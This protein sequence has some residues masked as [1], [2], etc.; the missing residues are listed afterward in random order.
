MSHSTLFQHYFRHITW[1]AYMSYYFYISSV[2]GWC[3]VVSCPG[4]LSEKKT[5]TKNSASSEA[6]AQ[7]K[8]P[9][10]HH[11]ATQDLYLL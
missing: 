6:Q 4:I 2:L 8:S 5:T 7:V 9:S 1:A 10:L 3:S 11:R